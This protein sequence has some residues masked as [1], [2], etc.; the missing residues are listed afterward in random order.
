MEN[1]RN[2]LKRRETVESTAGAITHVAGF[3]LLRGTA[4]GNPRDGEELIGS[5][6]RNQLL[7]G[8]MARVESARQSIIDRLQL[9][10]CSVAPQPSGKALELVRA[11]WAAYD[12]SQQGLSEFHW[13]TIMHN[14]GHMTL[15]G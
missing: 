13:I 10:K 14:I 12:T 6:Y 2:N 1:L 15:F 3:S 5:A 11:T 9:Y 4:P 8:R 7:L